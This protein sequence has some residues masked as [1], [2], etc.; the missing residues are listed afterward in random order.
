MATFSDTTNPTPFGFFDSD[1]DFK[2]EADNIVT[3]VKRK[4]GDDILSVELTKKQIWSNFE[5]SCLEYGSILNQYQ[6]KSQ[7]VQFL[8][9]P[10]TGS[11]GHMSGSEGKYPRENLEYLIRFAEPY[12]MEAGVGG[13]YNMFS[14][15]IQLEKGRQDYDIYSELKN[16]AGHVMF[17]SASNAAPKT[18]IKVSEV[19]HFGPEAA[20]RFFDTTSAINYLNNEFSFESFTP[21][22][23]FYVLPVFEDILRAGQLDLS[24]RVRRSNYSYKLIGSNLRIYP[25]PTSA[26]PKE[27]YIRI[28]YHPDPLNPAYHDE[29]IGGVSNLSNIPFGNLNY[30]KINS[31]GRQ[32]IR[33]YALA[34]SREQL[35]LIR[36]KFG[37]I[38]VPGADVT[39]NGTDLITQGRADRDALVTQLKEMLDTLTYDKIMETASTRAEFKNSLDFHLCQMA[40]QSLWGR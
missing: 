15:S 13:S 37:N 39:L 6:A 26:D 5:E 22:T 36:S 17:Q 40:S 16:H 7:L 24:N 28:M 23:I 29:T 10:T 19:F 34:L 1:D 25:T 33:Q 11:D 31:I 38:P 8:G 27:L 9:M 2:A 3:F 35:G 18:K 32:W 4:M 14:G 21:E 30:N 20:Y 12:A